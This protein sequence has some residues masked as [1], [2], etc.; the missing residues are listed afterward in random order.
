[1]SH[2]ENDGTDLIGSFGFRKTPEQIAKEKEEK[3]QREADKIEF[4]AAEKKKRDAV[5]STE[6][7]ARQRRS[8]ENLKAEV[9]EIVMAANPNFDETDAKILYENEL[10]KI[11]AVENFKAVYFGEGRKTTFGFKM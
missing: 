1:M 7:R 6:R 9:V 4:L 10:K 2:F 11:I 3:A 8:E 5:D